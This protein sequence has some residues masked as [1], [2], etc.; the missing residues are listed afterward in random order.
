VHLLAHLIQPLDHLCVGGDAEILALLHQ[1][2]LI[3]EIAQHVL[4]V[5]GETRVGL[6]A[7]L[8][9]QLVQQLVT[10]ALEFRAGDDVVVNAGDDL[11]DHRIGSQRYRQQQSKE[12]GYRAFHN[13]MWITFIL[14]QTLVARTPSSAGVCPVF[15]PQLAKDEDF[16]C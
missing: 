1:Q 16:Q 8:L 5:L 7:K 4:L 14:A 9:L 13:N 10:A 11:F 2:V 15:H 6:G 12:K 3:D